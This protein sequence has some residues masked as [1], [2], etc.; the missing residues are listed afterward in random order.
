MQDKRLSMMPV[1]NEYGGIAGRVTLKQ[2]I[3]VIVGTVLEDDP[4][5]AMAGRRINQVRLERVAAVEREVVP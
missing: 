5:S 3:G 2:I 1:T 4:P